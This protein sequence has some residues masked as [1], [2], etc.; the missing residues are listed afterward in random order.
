MTDAEILA[1]SRASLVSIIQ[2][3]EAFIDFWSDAALDPISAPWPSFVICKLN[4]IP[5]VHV[6]DGKPIGWL[7]IEQT[8]SIKPVPR[9]P[10]PA[11]TENRVSLPGTPRLGS[12]ADLSRMSS[13]LS[14]TRKRFSFF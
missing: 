6:T 11:S 14:A 12:R 3:D 7:V 10:S 1:V 2:L 13:T 9:T 8:H 5:G 4:N